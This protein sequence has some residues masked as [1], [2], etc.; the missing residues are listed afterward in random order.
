MVKQGGGFIAVHGSII[1]QE[2]PEL[3]T[4][5]EVLWIK[6]ELVGYKPL[7]IGAYYEPHEND[8]HSP[9]EFSKSLEKATKLNTNI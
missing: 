8:P 2:V 5:C 9:F 1:A 6:M 3:K 7:L 4:D